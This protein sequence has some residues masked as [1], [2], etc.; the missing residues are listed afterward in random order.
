MKVEQIRDVGTLSGDGPSVTFRKTAF[1]E[2]HSPKDNEEQENASSTGIADNTI[3][4]DCSDLLADYRAKMREK[5]KNARKLL[6]ENS[7]FGPII[8]I[9]VVSSSRFDFI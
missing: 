1:C 3:S 8:S 4:P 2:Q 7:H 5:V 9:P 6:A